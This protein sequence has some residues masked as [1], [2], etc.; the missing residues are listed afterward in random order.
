V[1]TSPAAQLYP[2]HCQAGEQVIVVP[3]GTGRERL[4]GA[5]IPTRA[6]Y[7]VSSE[8]SASQLKSVVSSKG[9]KVAV[10]TYARG[11]Q[12]EANRLKSCVGRIQPIP[13]ELADNAVASVEITANSGTDSLAKARV[14]FHRIQRPA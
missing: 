10:S 1:I 8:S 2:H 14:V 3:S 5:V 13:H 7:K 4:C 11:L 6:A 12:C 9:K